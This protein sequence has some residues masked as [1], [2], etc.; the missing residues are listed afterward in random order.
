MLSLIFYSISTLLLGWSYYRLVKRSR[1]G[2]AIVAGDFLFVLGICIYPIALILGWVMPGIEGNSYLSRHGMPGFIVSFHLMMVAVGAA[3][4]TLLSAR[5]CKDKYVRRWEKAAS[6][7]I[8]GTQYWLYVIAIGLLTYATYFLL[9]GFEVAMANA[10]A[11]RGGDFEGFGE[12]DKYLF[13]KT[14]AAIALY[15]C[16]AVPF[17]AKFKANHRRFL[18]VA[19]YLTLLVAAFANS[20]S[21][22]IVLKYLVAPSVIFFL[23]SGRGLVKSTAKLAVLSIIFFVAIAVALYGKSFGQYL[24]YMYGGG[25]DVCD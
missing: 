9:V 8:P 3:T 23:A 19:M 18:F 1:V 14:V 13:L 12:N 11:A 20:I 7:L 17:L 2:V 16:T 25:A 15:A 22:I 21:R 6:T 4:G 10:A 5:K 24:R